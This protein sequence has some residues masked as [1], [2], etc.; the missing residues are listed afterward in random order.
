MPFVDDNAFC[1]TAREIE[2]KFSDWLVIWGVY[3]RQFV[4]FPLFNAPRMRHV[5]AMPCT[6]IPSK[7]LYQARRKWRKQ[8]CQSQRNCPKPQ[9]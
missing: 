5:Q 2:E 8:V 9:P 7:R 6:A 3:T 4:A 1:R